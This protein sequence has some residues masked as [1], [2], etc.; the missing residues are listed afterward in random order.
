M[1]QLSGVAVCL[2]KTLRQTGSG[3]EISRGKNRC[4]CIS[5]GHGN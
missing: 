5:G 1:S 3:A 2:I 4:N